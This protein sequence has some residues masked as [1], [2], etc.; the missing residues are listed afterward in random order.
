MLPCRYHIWV[1]VQ[2]V[3]PEGSAP[4]DPLAAVYGGLWALALTPGRLKF[5]PGNY[6]RTGFPTWASLGSR[7]N[8]ARK[9]SGLGGLAS[10]LLGL[11]SP[12][13]GLHQAP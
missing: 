13:A 1:F 10:A 11:S 8:R 9:G 7:M 12:R 4:W 3:Q 5:C 2:P 6:L